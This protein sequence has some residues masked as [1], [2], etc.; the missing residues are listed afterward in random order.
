MKGA[1]HW[2]SPGTQSFRCAARL[3][4]V[5]ARASRENNF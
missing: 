1:Q 2:L 5:D 4:E 3:A